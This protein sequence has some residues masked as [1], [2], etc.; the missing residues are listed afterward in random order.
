MQTLDYWGR[1]VEHNNRGDFERRGYF[2]GKRLTRRPPR[3]YL[4]SP[5][6]SFHDSTERLLR[7]VLPEVEAWKIGINHD[8]RSAVK[9]LNRVRV[10]CGT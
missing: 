10:R 7:F 5:L 8:W 9:I 6:F 3:I 2:S 4:V 1:V